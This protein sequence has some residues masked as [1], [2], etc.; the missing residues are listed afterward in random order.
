MV[1]MWFIYYVYRVDVKPTARE[2]RTMQ[3]ENGPIHQEHEF[4]QA[5]GNERGRCWRN[6][7]TGETELGFSW[8]KLLHSPDT[9]GGICYYIPKVERKVQADSL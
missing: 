4:R 5:L 7:Q 3:E 9:L 8:M 1:S 2:T 6:E